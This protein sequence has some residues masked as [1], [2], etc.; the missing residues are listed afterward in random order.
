MAM[1]YPDTV[2]VSV[3]PIYNEVDA[4][5]ICSGDTL[6]WGNDTLTL[7]GGYAQTFSSVNG[8]DSTVV[9]TL[10][11][12]LTHEINNSETI[13]SND[14][15]EVGGGWQNTSG[16]YYDY[17]LTSLGCDSV[18]ITDLTVNQAHEIDSILSVCDSIQVGGEWQN[19][20]GVY[21]DS[22]LTST[23]CDSIIVFDLTVNPSYIIDANIS[24]CD[25]DSILLEG[26][27]QKVAGIYTDSL[28]TLLGCDSITITN[29]Y[30]NPIYTQTIDT[31]ICSNDSI[32][33]EG[34]WQNTSGN[35][36]DVFTSSIGCDSTIN[37]NL[38]VLSSPI[39]TIS[40]DTIICN[41]GSSIISAGGGSHYIWSTGETTSSII[42]NPGVTTTYEV[43]VS[44]A[45]CLEYASSTVSIYQ[46]PIAVDDTVYANQ[47]DVNIIKDI[48]INDT[49]IYAH[50]EILNDVSNGVVTVQVNGI[51]DYT[52]NEYYFGEDSFTY[53]LTDSI[54]LNYFDEATVYYIINNNEALLIPN[55]ITPNGDGIHDYFSIGGLV[56]YPDNELVIFNRWG[57]EIYSSK[58]YKNDW[59]GTGKDGVTILPNG[60]YYYV[61]KLNDSE[62]KSFSG[63]IELVK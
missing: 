19:T 5:S 29:L 56:N 27:W 9:M 50:Y 1:S 4:A 25:G 46:E 61:L 23:G 58:P 45:I 55:A 53:R 34:A 57:N 2:F 6:F 24:I 3:N 10:T 13:C 40:P 54:C 43:T 14:S 36:V 12:N 41:G 22:L 30:V 16:I 31:A 49:Y 8:C 26:D 28:L 52:P 62:N 18:I 35:Y 20:S 32:Y 11:E 63:Y 60:T 39:V 33:L 42:V 38:T 15:L 47:N 59:N 37:T 51:S 48:S 7:G 21:Y 17:L 44:I